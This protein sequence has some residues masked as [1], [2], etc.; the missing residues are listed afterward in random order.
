MSFD[1]QFISAIYALN[2]LLIFCRT[3]AI[4]ML[5]PAFGE[6]YVPAR[7]KIFLS[8]A[9]TLVI[10]PLIE[11][12]Y[13]IY[14]DFSPITIFLNILQEMFIGVFYGMIT[15]IMISAV[16]IAGMIVAT[17]TGLA[18]AMLF[19]VNQGAQ[20]AVIGNFYSLVAALLIFSTGLYHLFL[21]SIATTYTL[22]PLGTWMDTESSSYIIT[23]L[24]SD[25]FLVGLKLAAPQI[26]VG[27]A[28]YI[29]MGVVSKLMP[30]MQVFF[31]VTPVQILL[32]FFIMMITFGASM[33]WFIE[34]FADNFMGLIQ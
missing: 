3:S 18:S 14:K 22:F 19:D 27:L 4:I 6:I 9:I 8:V 5:L 23:K 21:G 31:I 13:I 25:G 15:R 16:H 10:L 1:L 24:I 7:I 12:Q 11:S 26:V 30:T 28:L 29:S 33:M 17:Q 20:G 32:S 2:F 34:N